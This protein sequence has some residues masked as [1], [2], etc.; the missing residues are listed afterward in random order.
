MLFRSPEQAPLFDGVIGVAFLMG[1]PVLIWGLWKFELPAEIKVGAGV[2][3]V[4]FLFWLFSSQQIRYLL[5]VLPVVA[6]GICAAGQAISREKKALGTALQFS[7]VAS[8]VA[9]L[10]TGTAWFSQKAAVRVALGGE[11][12][13]AYLARNIDYY[14]YYQ[15]LNR[16][17]P[18][19]SRVWLIN[20][21]RDTYN[22]DRRYFSD[23]LFEDWTLRAMVWEARSADELRAKAR[24]RGLNYVLA[25]HDFLFDYDRST[26][27]DERKS[28]TENEEKLKIA[29]EFL[30]DKAGTVRA[31]AKFSLV[32][33]F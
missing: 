29:K 1:L 3:A 22:L 25:R 31:D 8:A 10:L 26:L 4:M 18:A 20:M 19:D 14:P 28:R 13:D 7:L 16:E 2:V 15:V 27:V 5:P 21:R 32:K 6:L 9:A 24:E 33:V 17:T 11:S 30:L 23:Y 12:R